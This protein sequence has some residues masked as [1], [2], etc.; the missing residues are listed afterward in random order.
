MPTKR[1]EVHKA[2][3]LI[4]ELYTE[5]RDWVLLPQNTVSGGGLLKAFALSHQTSSPSPRP[6]ATVTWES[7]EP[8]IT[9]R[10]ERLLRG[11]LALEVLT[12]D[13]SKPEFIVQGIA[14]EVRMSFITISA[15]IYITQERG[16][17]PHLTLCWMPANSPSRAVAAKPNKPYFFPDLSAP[18]WVWNLLNLSFVLFR[19]VIE[20]LGCLCYRKSWA[21]LGLASWNDDFSA[22][23]WMLWY[24]MWPL[25]SRACPVPI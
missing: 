14:V 6:P 11:E 20:T 8:S 15:A 17:F 7:T 22:I 18:F 4:W 9:S 1:D 21:V 19:G 25:L 5:Q 16:F 12:T 13:H 23:T 3:F 24:V 2:W 10:G